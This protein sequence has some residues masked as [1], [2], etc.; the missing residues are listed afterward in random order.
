M[1]DTNLISMH[2]SPTEMVNVNRALVT[3]RNILTP[4]CRN[5]MP[6][7]RAQYDIDE[8]Q[9]SLIQKVNDNRSKRP[10][11]SRPD[12]D[13]DKF[14]ADFQD[15][16]FLEL[17]ISSLHE[18]SNM[19]K[20]TLILHDY[21]ALQ[22]ALRDHDYTCQRHDNAGSGFKEKYEEL[23]PFFSAGRPAE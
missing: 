1:K 3:L 2:F 14:N 4:K 7:E 9:K 19:A 20:D 21:D 5:L 8:H 15:H 11:L 10:E 18:I 12:V 6:E 23:K 13:W 17:V 22:A 16:N